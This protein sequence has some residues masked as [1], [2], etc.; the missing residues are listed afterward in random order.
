MASLPYPRS[1]LMIA[2]VFLGGYGILPYPRTSLM[3]AVVF[4]GGYGIPA[5]PTQP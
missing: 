2:V 1:P 3:I 4:L 5:I